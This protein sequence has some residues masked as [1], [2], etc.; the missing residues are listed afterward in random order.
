MYEI[1]SLGVYA[2]SIAED[3]AKLSRGEIDKS[4]LTIPIEIIK[5]DLKSL[6]ESRSLFESS[7]RESS[8]KY[9]LIFE[10]G[11]EILDRIREHL[12]DYDTEETIRNYVLNRSPERNGKTELEKIC[13][14]LE[15]LENGRS[16]DIP[17][18]LDFFDNLALEC[19]QLSR[20]V[21]E[22]A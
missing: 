3:I 1:L 7:G 20:L 21:S 17:Y 6:Y 15:G 11:S 5:N 12:R 18:I 16:A 10:S 13:A 22:A 4:E 9:H 14:E 8:G 19:L 2:Q